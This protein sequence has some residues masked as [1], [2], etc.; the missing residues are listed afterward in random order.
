[1]NRKFI[2]LAVFSIITLLF[3]CA[4]AQAVTKPKFATPK[5]AEISDGET[6]PIRESLDRRYRFSKKWQ[7]E[8]GV[9]GGDYLGDEW[10]NTWDAGARYYLH[11]SN[12]F[13]V[14]ASYIYS[15][16]RAHS[17]TPFGASL[18]TNNSHLFDAELMLSNDCAFRSGHTIIECDLFLTLGVGSMYINHLWKPA[19][20]LGGGMK[21]Y[22]P[23]PWFAVRFDVNTVLHPTPVPGGDTFNSDLVMN[24]GL[25]FLLPAKKTDEMAPQ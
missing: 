14:G 4:S 24:L 8:L 3:F 1:M 6:S 19:G 15:P 25:S 12:T 20:V 7:S 11:I 17:T 22:T 2:N 9:F 23:V 18:T 5:G 13:S 21:I 10:K 16:I